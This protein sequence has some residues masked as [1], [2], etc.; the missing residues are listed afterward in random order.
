MKKTAIL[1]S[2]FALLFSGSVMGQEL[3]KDITVEQEIT[4]SRREASRIAV[5][6]R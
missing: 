6:P 1:S 3:H 2:L 4:P 5:L